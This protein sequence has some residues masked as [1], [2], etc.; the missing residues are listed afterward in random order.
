[1]LQIE[2]ENLMPREKLLKFGANTLDNKELLAIFLR[3]GIKNCP[4][5]QLS[6]AVLTHF[7]SLRQLINADRQQFCAFKGIGIT[8]FIQLQACTEMTK[9]YL[10]EELQQ[11]QE[12]NSTDTARIYLQTALEQREREIFLVLFL[13]NQHRLIKQEEMF[14][15]TIN[16]AVIHPRE[17][18]KTALYCNA[19]AMILAH[20][21]PSGI[22]EPS[23][24]DRHIT[25]RI[26][27]AANLM[28]IRLLD[29]FIIGKGCYFS[30][31]EAGWL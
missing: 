23:Q 11:N 25:E 27:Q 14:L 21:H 19:A 30:F 7:G 15:G 18:I 22:A 8:Q 29:H 13:D 20:N 26:R 9:R 28:D 6:E 1:M 24:S 3:T 5:M 12:F 10:L 17:I 2:K 16:S 4:V 31:S